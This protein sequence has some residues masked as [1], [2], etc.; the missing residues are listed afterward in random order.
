MLTGNKKLTVCIKEK[1]NSMVLCLFIMQLRLLK[2]F[3]IRNIK[4]ERGRDGP[5][6]FTHP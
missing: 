3:F 5:I 4:E 1:C 2:E 6:P